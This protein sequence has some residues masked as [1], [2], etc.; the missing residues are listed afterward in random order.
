MPNPNRDG[1]Q[2]LTDLTTGAPTN[3]EKVARVAALIPDPDNNSATA[4]GFLDEMSPGAAIQLLVEL[5][6]L[7]ASI[8]NV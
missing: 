1:V 2:A 3:K 8:T 5:A 7:E 6:A 4:K